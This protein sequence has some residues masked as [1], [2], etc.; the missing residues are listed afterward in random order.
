MHQRVVLLGITRPMNMCAVFGRILFELL[1]V[2]V[3]VRERVFFDLGSELAK[4]GPFWYIGNGL[5]AILAH[6]PDQSIVSGLVLLEIDKSR[7]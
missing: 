6:P 4:I 5:V 7:G 3:Q 2:L 1:E